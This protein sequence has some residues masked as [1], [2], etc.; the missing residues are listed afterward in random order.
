MLFWSESVGNV[1][2]GGASI[3]FRVVTNFIR[4]STEFITDFH[5]LSNVKDSAGISENG[6][7]ETRLSFDSNT[8][9]ALTFQLSHSKS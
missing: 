1:R 8:H 9:A 5:F 7:G 2:E 6:N 3:S 4:L